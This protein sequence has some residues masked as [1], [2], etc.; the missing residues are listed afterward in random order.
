MA[1]VIPYI[2]YAIGALAAISI[3][4]VVVRSNT[5]KAT[6]QINEANIKALQTQN[7]IQAG[8]LT[9]FEKDK[10]QLKEQVAQLTTKVDTLS[11]IPLEKIEQHMADTNH[12][13]RAVLPLLDKTTTEKT[14]TSTTKVTN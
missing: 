3:A 5:S 9:A 12:I 4:F 14:I 10:N 6:N 2:A 1:E 7:A 8:Q 13:L 11:S